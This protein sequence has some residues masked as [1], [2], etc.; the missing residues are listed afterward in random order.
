M[1]SLVRQPKEILFDVSSVLGRAASALVYRGIQILPGENPCTDGKRNI[2]LPEAMKR[3]M[4]GR[5]IDYVRYVVHHEQGHI[6]YTD[7]DAFKSI[8]DRCSGVRTPITNCLE[9]I[10]M[11]GQAMRISKGSFDTFSRGRKI[12][13]EKWSASFK[14]NKLIPCLIHLLYGGHVDPGLR[15]A[16]N[17]P[18]SILG[19][20]HDGIKDLYPHIDALAG[21]LQTSDIRWLVDELCAR[22]V[23]AKTNHPPEGEGGEGGEGEGG[24][25]EGGSDEEEFHDDRHP[26]WDGGFSDDDPS[27]DFKTAADVIPTLDRLQEMNDCA[28]SDENTPWDRAGGGLPEKGFQDLE[29]L[30]EERGDG[31]NVAWTHQ[32][33]SNGMSLGQPSGFAPVKV[34][35]EKNVRWAKKNVGRLTQVIS[36]LR[37][38]SRSA[39]GKPKDS[40]VRI[41]RPSVPAFIRGLSCNL[42]RKRVKTL[43]R[44]TA[45]LFLVDDS[46]SMRGPRTIHAW[47]AAALLVAACERLK[48]PVSVI[49]FN[50]GWAMCKAFSVPMARVKGDFSFGGGG[51]T[52]IY[53][54]FD[55]GVKQLLNRR[56]DRK[57]L[58]V[59]TDG[60]T[61]KMAPRLIKAKQAGIECIPIMFGDDAVRLANPGGDW[62]RTGALVIPDK[63]AATLGPALVKALATRL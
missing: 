46:S 36:L 50:C 1:Q 28:Y 60:W 61:D 11:E 21:Q 53:E 52:E 55:Q 59:L 58:F 3:F 17:E 42:L 19:D 63:D 5:E 37:G 4:T 48:F 30:P 40:G 27:A 43:H 15:H 31:S 51:G 29:V 41:H 24:E 33:S 12:A 45:L 47:R 35:S 7:M 16:A 57:V 34:S 23:D 18:G 13:L 54:P 14:G 2:Y 49:R 44:G 22:L 25:G 9:D 32:I 8:S 6:L 20:L 10:R 26:E 38:A 39:Y 56:E 62:Y